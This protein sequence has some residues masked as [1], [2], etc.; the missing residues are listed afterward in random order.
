MNT[1]N[2]SPYTKLQTGGGG[3]NVDQHT[4]GGVGSGSS[5]RWIWKFRLLELTTLI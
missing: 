5:G 4:A 3:V 2:T 1:V